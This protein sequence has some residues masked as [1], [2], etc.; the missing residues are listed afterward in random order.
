MTA[1]ST[2]DFVDTRFNSYDKN[3]NI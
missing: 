1:Q 3:E 2:F